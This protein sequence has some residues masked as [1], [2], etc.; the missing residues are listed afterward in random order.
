MNTLAT[1][2]NIEAPVVK[3]YRSKVPT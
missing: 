1:N 3:R 2:Q